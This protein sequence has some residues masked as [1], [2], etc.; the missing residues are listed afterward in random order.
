MPARGAELS[1]RP[2]L[3][4]LRSLLGTRVEC[5]GLTFECGPRLF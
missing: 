2:F 1:L 5:S 4:H 3:E